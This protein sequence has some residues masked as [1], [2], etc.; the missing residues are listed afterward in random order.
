MNHRGSLEQKAKETLRRRMSPLSKR[1]N[2]LFNVGIT[3]SVSIF[4]RLK[5]L[6]FKLYS[7][8]NL[9]RTHV[10]SKPATCHSFC[11]CIPQ[12]LYFYM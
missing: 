3:S 5:M 8:I 11:M 7:L 6:A 1:E 12:N 10:M 9:S 4:G 2:S